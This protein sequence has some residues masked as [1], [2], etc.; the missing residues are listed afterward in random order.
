LKPWARG[1]FELLLHA[2]LH[3]RDGDDFDRRMAVISYDIAIEVAITTYLTLNPIQRGN[4]EYPKDRVEKWLR[5]FHTKVEFFLI[6]VRDRNVALIYD[7][8]A[9]RTTEA[10]NASLASRMDALPLV[11]WTMTASAWKWSPSVGTIVFLS[12]HHRLTCSMRDWELVSKM[13]SPL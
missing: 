8:P 3:R 2:E 12:Q 4:R 11:P 1:P 5:N 10:P 6:E 13:A 9:D 7:Q